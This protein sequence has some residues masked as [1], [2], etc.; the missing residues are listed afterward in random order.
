MKFKT[1]NLYNNDPIAISVES[2]GRSVVFDVKSLLSKVEPSNLASDTIWKPLEDYIFYKGTVFE[3]E[4]MDKYVSLQETL[5]S[6]MINGTSTSS[7]VILFDIIAMIDIEDITKWVK[8]YELVKAPAALPD[9]FVS[10]AGSGLTR[11]QTYTKGEY[12][13]IAALTISSKLL[14]GPLGEYATIRAD[15]LQKG[16]YEYSLINILKDREN[17]FESKPMHKLMG[18]MNNM[19]TIAGA[20]TAGIPMSRLIPSEDIPLWLLSLAYIKRMSI[21]DITKDNSS[22]NIITRVYNLVNN[23]IH[24]NPNVSNTIKDKKPASDGEEVE[25]LIESYRTASDISPGTEVEYNWAYRDPYRILRNMGL[26]EHDDELTKALKFMNIVREGNMVPDG[27]V[28]IMGHILHDEIDVRT[29]YRVN[30]DSV[31]NGLSV[32]F[33]WCKV[34]GL[35]DVALLLTT[36]LDKSKDIRLSQSTS[37][38]KVKREKIEYLCEKSYKLTKVVETAKNR[39]TTNPI[40]ETIKHIS[41]SYFSSN[42]VYMAP[43]A[44]LEGRNKRTVVPSNLKPLLA[45][46]IDALNA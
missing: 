25:S 20:K 10:V 14:I 26:G 32:A 39:T 43:N 16:M 6:S 38:S 18:V 42:L 17:L 31:V 45:E 22:K 21:N 23:V 9:E 33:V 44:M 5:I 28:D 11:V 27:S 4:L 46:F 35:Y 13:G 19:Y 41:E 7:M 34:N 40:T 24:E 36:V 1:L 30:M 2:N 37:K 29:R 3:N 15:T 8:D 12:Y